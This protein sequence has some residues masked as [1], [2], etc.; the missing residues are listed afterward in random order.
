VSWYS[1]V[2]VVTIYGL[3]SPGIKSWWGKIFSIYLDWPWGPPNLPYNGFIP[4]GKV[5]RKGI[6]LPPPFSIEVKERVYL[7]HYSSSGHH[8][9]WN[10]LYL[11]ENVLFHFLHGSFLLACTKYMVIYRCFK[12]DLAQKVWQGIITELCLWHRHSYGKEFLISNKLARCSN[13]CGL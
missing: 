3:G 11:T 4:R 1:V 2:C 9:L 10:L 7:Y 5:A 6:D 13:F 8:G 12:G